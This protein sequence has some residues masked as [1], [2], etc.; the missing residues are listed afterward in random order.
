MALAFVNAYIGNNNNSGAAITAVSVTTTIA[1]GNFA[2]AFVTVGPSA[3]STPTWST[4]TGWT[5]QT[6]VALISAATTKA[7]CAANEEHHRETPFRDEYLAFL[8]RHDSAF[9]ER[10]LWD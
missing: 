5:D 3:A 10:Y 8:K 9:D 6:G 1:S 2:V 7:S 4:P